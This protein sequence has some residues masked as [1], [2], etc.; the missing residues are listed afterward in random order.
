MQEITLGSLLETMTTSTRV[1]IVNG[2]E[3]IFMGTAVTA[4]ENTSLEI[5]E[6][7]VISVKAEKENSQIVYI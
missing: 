4:F 2:T 7:T 5:L 6:E 1:R 3:T